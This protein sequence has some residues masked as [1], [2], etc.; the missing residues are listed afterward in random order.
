MLLANRIVSVIVLLFLCELFLVK[1]F[2][3]ELADY[4]LAEKTNIAIGIIG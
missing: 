2:S 3:S 4:L 1:D